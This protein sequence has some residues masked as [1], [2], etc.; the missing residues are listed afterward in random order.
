V[1]NTKK[2]C[3][4]DLNEG[5]LSRSMNISEINTSTDLKEIDLFVW[6]IQIQ[7]TVGFLN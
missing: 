1:N 6:T 5:L 7:I 4:G 3:S 2:S